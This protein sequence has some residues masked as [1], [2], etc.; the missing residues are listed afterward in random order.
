MT[1]EEK[2]HI[3][4]LLQEKEI[5][6]EMQ[7]ISQGIYTGYDLRENGNPTEPIKIEFKGGAISVLAAPTSHGKTMSL[8]NFALPILA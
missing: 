4:E 2:E 8:I 1:T 6:E 5:I 3:E 7:V